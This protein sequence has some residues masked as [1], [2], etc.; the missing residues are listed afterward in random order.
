MTTRVRLLFTNDLAT[1]DPLCKD[2]AR[3][4]FLDEMLLRKSLGWANRLLSTNPLSWAEL[5]P[6][7]LTSFSLQM[8][9]YSWV[10]TSS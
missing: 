6:F 9:S 3:T 2:F 7:C 4:E 1:D 8:V 5:F 10:Q